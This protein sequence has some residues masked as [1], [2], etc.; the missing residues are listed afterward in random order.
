MFMQPGEYG[1]SMRA[2]L[3]NEISLMM[4]AAWMLRVGLAATTA[5]TYLSLARSTIEA[6]LG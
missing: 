5:T 6:Q 2:S 1:L 3:H 4:W